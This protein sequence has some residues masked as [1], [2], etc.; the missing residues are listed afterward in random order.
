MAIYLTATTQENNISVSDNQAKVVWKTSEIALAYAKELSWRIFPCNPLNKRP[1]IEGGFKNATTDERTLCRWWTQWPNALIGCEAGDNIGGAFV[2]DLDVKAHKPTGKVTTLEQHYAR[3]K[4]ATGVDLATL[5]TWEVET[6][7]G[8]RHFYI[9]PPDG[10]AL[11][12]NATDVGGFHSVDIRS[13]G[14]YIILP[15]STPSSGAQYKWIVN[16][17]KPIVTSAELTA[18]AGKAGTGKSE[19]VS[20]PPRSKRALVRRHEYACTPKF[21]AEIKGAL[22]FLTAYQDRS[23]WMNRAYELKSLLVYDTKWSEG[24]CAYNILDEWSQGAPNYDAKVNRQQWDSLDGRTQTRTIASLFHDAAANGW[25]RPETAGK[26]VKDFY[27]Y[28]PMNNFI[29]VKTR[30]MWSASAVNADLPPVP[31]TDAQG[32]SLLDDNGDQIY[33][34]ASDWISANHVADQMTWAPGYPMLIKDQVVDQGGFIPTKGYSIFNR[35]RPPPPLSPK[36]DASKAGIWVGLVQMIFGDDDAKDI[37]N[38]FAHCVQKPQEKINNALVLGSEAFGIGKDTLIA[39]LKVAIGSWNWGEVS[40]L[41]L[42]KDFNE[43]LQNVVLRISEAHDLGEMNRFQFYERMKDVLATPPET[44]RINPKFAHPYYIPKLVNV[45]ITT[46]HKDALFLP[47]GDRRHFVAWS[48]ITPE[49]FGKTQQERD[50]F[51]TALWHWYEHEDGFHHVAAYL[52]ALDISSFNPFAPPRKTEAFY[53]I[54]ELNVAPEE[55]QLTGIIE[56]LGAPD[57]L[58]LDMLWKFSHFDNQDRQFAEWLKDPANSRAVPKK[59]S[60][61]GYTKIKSDR[62]DGQWKIDGSMVAVYGKA[63]LN[64]H[65]RLT[66]ARGLQKSG[67][68]SATTVWRTSP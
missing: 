15:P 23:S 36:G 32:S 34:V 13:N 17:H 30:D 21:I 53:E 46:N 5:G 19:D 55:N 65:Q 16:A 57:A 41:M 6:G 68:D 35:Y 64:L 63:N 29:C 61:A 8:G 22:S 52:A 51:W 14:G 43:F 44:I 62:K 7:S 50:A 37:I 40:P 42:T 9:K 2:I 12:K 27:A 20:K 48:N 56:D 66:A 47:P 49:A 18:F 11:P 58:T 1:L 24:D 59:L 67:F 10:V 26:S 38:W 3:I 39:A 54:V 4:D 33:M 60:A 28:R 45:I 31:L 25:V